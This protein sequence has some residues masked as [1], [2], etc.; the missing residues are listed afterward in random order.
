MD[1]EE[2]QSYVEQ[3]DC[4][5]DTFLTNPLRTTSTRTRPNLSEHVLRWDWSR[6]HLSGNGRDALIAMD[7]FVAAATTSPSTNPVRIQRNVKVF[8]EQPYC[9]CLVQIQ[10]CLSNSEGEEHKTNCWYMEFTFDPLDSISFIEVWPL[11]DS[12]QLEDWQPELGSNRL[13]TSSVVAGQFASPVRTKTV[14][15]GGG[16]GGGVVAKTVPTDWSSS[17]SASDV[18]TPSDLLHAELQ[19]PRK[20]WFE[21]TLQQRLQVHA[22]PGNHHHDRPEWESIRQAWIHQ[23][24][25]LH[26]AGRHHGVDLQ[27]PDSMRSDSDKLLRTYNEEESMGQAVVEYASHAVRTLIF[28]SSD[29][30]WRTPPPRKRSNALNESGE[31]RKVVQ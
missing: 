29:K 6:K 26:E 20:L 19:K 21:H 4:Y 8:R 7:L 23:T 14:G 22:P 12:H 17:S 3:C 5:L 30:L 25:A 1:P 10:S 18:I 15:G 13:S 27:F 11:M 9:R 2:A 24:K 16:G 31:M 28:A